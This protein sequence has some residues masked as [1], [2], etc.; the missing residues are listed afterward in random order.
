MMRTCNSFALRPLEAG[1]TGP[2]ARLA[3]PPLLRPPPRSGEIMP[4]KLTIFATAVLAML[5]A[6]TAAPA[7]DYPARPVSLVVAFPPG[8]ASDLL[9]RILGRKLDQLLGQPLVIDNRPGAGGNIAAEAVAHAA[10]DG[11]TLLL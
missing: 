6:M 2:L 4:A 11:Y 8:G 10:A 5:C 7:A 9:A 1:S 3:I